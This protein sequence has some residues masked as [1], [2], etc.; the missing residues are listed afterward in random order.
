MPRKADKAYETENNVFPKRLSEIMKER[1][2]NQTTLAEKITKQYLTIQRQTISLYMNGQSK[3]DTERLTAIAK[4]LDV[5]AD[6]LLGLS[7]AKST[8]NDLR[9]IC[10]YTG[11]S[12][13]AVKFLRY[14]GHDPDTPEGDI[15]PFVLSF[16]L[17]NHK[18]FQVLSGLAMAC[19]LAHRYHESSDIDAIEKFKGE[20][21]GELRQLG[22]DIWSAS[23]TSDM[24]IAQANARFFDCMNDVR[25]HFMPK[26]K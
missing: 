14:I 13:S 5:S 16:L 23:A 10:D 20:H 21:W 19:S 7:E 11:L 15:M 12:E 17:E 25:L 8:D 26:Q 18:F 1:G 2:E 6:W 4:T 22:A 24:F 3:P 9:S